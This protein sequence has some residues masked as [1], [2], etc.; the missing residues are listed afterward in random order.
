MTDDNSVERNENIGQ[1]IGMC[2]LSIVFIIFGIISIVGGIIC[3]M[4]LTKERYGYMDMFTR[5]NYGMVALYIF[6]GILIGLYNIALAIIIDACQKYRNGGSWN[7]SVHSSKTIGC[8]IMLIGLSSSA[9]LSS[10][11]PESKNAAIVESYLLSNNDNIRE[12]GSIAL[13]NAFVANPDS[14]EVA[15]Y[16]T[17]MN[18][19]STEA[20]VQK[21][22]LLMGNEIYFSSFWNKGDITGQQIENIKRVS[23]QYK[24]LNLRPSS[25]ILFSIVE[26]TDNFGLNKTA[27][28][29][30]LLDEN[31][32][33]VKHKTVESCTEFLQMFK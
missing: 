26:Y 9:F 24:A 28:L 33:I 29:A 13:S 1:D 18:D 22:L 3:A 16:I 8:I 25:H 32:T 12:I 2:S 31:N 30:F 17:N 23:A 4:N 27:N 14:V 10:C 21:V 7:R 19:F 5:I 11:S 15:E 20:A 6:G